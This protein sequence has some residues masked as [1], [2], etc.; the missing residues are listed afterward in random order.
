MPASFG[1]CFGIKPTFGL[2]ATW[3]PSA[4]GI[5]GH[6]GPMGWGVAETATM[7]G[8]M[9]G[10]DPRDPWSG[11]FAQAALAGQ[12]GDLRGVRIA[13]SP[14]L[15]IRPPAPEVRAV[16]DAAARDFEALGA[17]VEEVDPDLSGLFPAYDT[18]RICNRAAAYR[19]AGADRQRGA[20]DEI[21][22]RVLDQ[23]S[24]Y[25]VDDYV[26]ALAERER[27]AAG[28]AEFHETHDLLITPTM[29]TLP[30]PI[31]TG[32]GP[33]DD[34]WYQ[35]GG[36]VWSPYTFAFNM[37]QQPAASIPCGLARR[38]GDGPELPVG[39][40]IV[41]PRFADGRVLRAAAAYEATR[42]WTRPGFP[43]AGS[44]DAAGAA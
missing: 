41:G 16:I 25:G 23:A 13:Y 27:L 36:E 32:P 7:L 28:M 8:A 19:A 9:S 24:G 1:G 2:V 44:G 26:A 35:I 37:T 12:D 43:F 18:L 22:A 5:L 17:V 29:A 20:M 38:P 33:G 40:Q 11:P 30:L 39:L 34:H 10:P 4:A 15:G 31:G 21:V 14:T 6:T 3:P 42:A